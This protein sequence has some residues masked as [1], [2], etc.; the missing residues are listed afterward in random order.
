[1]KLV[2]LCGGKGSRLRSV[3]SSVPKPL[4]PVGNSNFLEILL[5]HYE[6]AGFSDVV[7][8]TGYM[9]DK[10]SDFV[11]GSKL[12]IDVSLVQEQ[13]PLGTG[14]AVRLAIDQTGYDG[15][16]LVVNGDTFIQDLPTINF[17]ENSAKDVDFALF[18]GLK[19]DGG[20]NRYGKF[21]VTRSGYLSLQQGNFPTMISYGIYLIDP[22]KYACAVSRGQRIDLDQVYR[23]L[24]LSGEKIHAIELN[25]TFI[26]IGVPED[27]RNFKENYE[28]SF[29]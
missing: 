16:M 28:N 13:E 9:A 21:Y 14:G 6:R 4:A 23:Q 19:L 2:L 25:S 20:D 18:G 17:F 1:M 3:V 12:G 29:S 8:S 5:K 27:Y 11:D 26:D 7:I 22:V 10:I 15:K 24:L